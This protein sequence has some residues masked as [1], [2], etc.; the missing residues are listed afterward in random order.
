MY[1]A[2]CQMFL[3]YNTQSN[4]YERYVWTVKHN[5]KMNNLDLTTQPKKYGSTHSIRLLVYSSL[6]PLLLPSLL[7]SLNVLLIIPLIKKNASLL[8]KGCWGRARD[9]S[10]RFCL[11]I[12]ALLV[13]YKLH[14]TRNLRCSLPCSLSPPCSLLPS[15]ELATEIFGEYPDVGG[16]WLWWRQWLWLTLWSM[17][18]RPGCSC[19]SISNPQQY[20]VKYFILIPFYIRRSPI[21]AKRSYLLKLRTAR[22]WP[23]QNWSPLFQMT[24]PAPFPFC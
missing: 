23:D 15:T 24:T 19:L 8:F 4:I 6:V 5:I 1:Q 9:S 14:S 11:D 20:L 12:K 17:S 22:K 7:T 13:E 10:W 18:Y 3:W 16:W 2:V 21:K